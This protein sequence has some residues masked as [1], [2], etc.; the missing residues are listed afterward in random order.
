MVDQTEQMNMLLRNQ[1]G[2]AMSDQ[3][4]LT[5]DLVKQFP[6]EAE[7][8]RKATR[9]E[10]TSAI[11]D[12]ELRRY[13]EE[14]LNMIG[15]AQQGLMDIDPEATRGVVEG[16]ELTKQKVMAGER[17]S[18]EEST[19]I[20][21]ILQKLGG[22]FSGMMGGGETK[23]YM[24]DGKVVEMTDREMMGAKNAG[25]LV[26]DVE[27]GIRDMEMGTYMVDGNPV[28]MTPMQ[29]QDAVESGSITPNR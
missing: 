17:L 10:S 22:A 29:Y 4:D 24:V 27:S 13:M 25:I 26:Q 8:F 7:A 23:S 19:G 16:L 12:S 15:A 20:M 11:A 21:A 6:D 14:E 2:A 1:T 28:E 9:Q 3:E 18:E 5:S